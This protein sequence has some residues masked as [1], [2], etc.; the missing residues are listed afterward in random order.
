[1]KLLNHPNIIKLYQVSRRNL[2][3]LWTPPLL[4]TCHTLSL[5]GSL[6]VVQGFRGCVGPNLGSTK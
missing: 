5:L 3:A 2:D 1:M 4:V 6:K